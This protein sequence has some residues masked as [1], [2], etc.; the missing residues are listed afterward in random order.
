MTTKECIDAYMAIKQDILNAKKRPEDM[1]PEQCA[2][3]A[4]VV[5]PTFELALQLCDNIASGTNEHA[6]KWKKAGELLRA[7]QRLPTEPAP[8]EC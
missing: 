5:S 6:V 3:N 1:T 2:G 8:S 4:L 7:K